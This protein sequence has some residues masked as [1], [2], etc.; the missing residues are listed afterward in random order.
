MYCF[1]TGRV[2][3]AYQC[4]GANVL[5]HLLSLSVFS[6]MRGIQWLTT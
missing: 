5:S 6:V 1:K 4:I 3:A 2:G